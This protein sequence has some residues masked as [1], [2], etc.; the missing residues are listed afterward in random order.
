WVRRS[1]TQST[2]DEIQEDLA[3]G[4][5]AGEAL[6]A[7]AVHAFQTGSA[8]EPGDALAAT[9]HAVVEAQLG[10]DPRC[11]VSASALGVDSRDPPGELGVGEIPGRGRAVAPGVVAAG[12]HAESGAHEADGELGLLRLDEGEHP[13]RVGSLSLA[14]KAAAFFNRSRSMRSVLF[15]ER[16]RR[17]SSRS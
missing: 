2:Y 13:H 9:G 6:A 17:S 14:K 7:P 12:G 5:A 3:V 11:A 8:H 15:S 4:I 16:S 1:G 10:M